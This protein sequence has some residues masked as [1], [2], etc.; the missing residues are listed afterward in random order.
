LIGALE[1]TCGAA[2]V[3]VSDVPG[4][5]GGEVAVTWEG[6][7]QD[8]PGVAYPVIYYEVQRDEDGW[9]VLDVVTAYQA[10]AYLSLVSCADTLVVGEPVSCSNYRVIG[11]SDNPLIYYESI[12]VCGYSID[13]IA[14]PPPTIHIED[15]I[16]FRVILWTNPTISDYRETCLYRGSEPGF[17]PDTPLLCTSAPF[18]QENDLNL[19]YYLAKHA[20]THGNLSSPS[21]EVTGAY[22]TGFDVPGFNSVLLEQNVPNPFNPV[23]TIGYYLPSRSRVCMR[24]YDI[25]GRLIK[26]LVE[27]D[28][29]ETGHH[30]VVWQG[31]D[32]SGKQ[33]PSGIYIYSLI[34]GTTVETKRMMLIR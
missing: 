13:N 29:Q 5:Q 11:Y 34:A 30:E 1:A 22:P 33:M 12:Q 15:G 24:I 4:D 26:T 20:D 21:N 10:P 9:T 16:D 28:N 17:T 3:L 23:T 19:Y 32:G 7:L 14:P 8:A 31:D 27:I 2:I 25:A 6:F 18:F